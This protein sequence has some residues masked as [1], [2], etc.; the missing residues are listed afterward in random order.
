MNTSLNTSLTCTTECVS[1]QKIKIVL[2]A[3]AIPMRLLYERLPFAK[4]F[5]CF[6]KIGKAAVLYPALSQ[7]KYSA[8]PDG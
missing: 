1:Y 5:L 6:L 8:G 2:S 7:G 4:V 3:Y